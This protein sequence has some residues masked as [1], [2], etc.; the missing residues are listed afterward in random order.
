M[1]NTPT[2]QATSW[3]YRLLDLL[4]R[5]KEMVEQLELLAKSQ[6]DLIQKGHTD[7]LLELLGRR[8]TIID[9]FTAS[10]SQLGEFTK[11]LDENMDS[12]STEDRNRIKSL[13]NEIGERLSQVMKRDEQ[14]QSNL[15]RNRDQVKQELTS[16][17]TARQARSAYVPQQRKVTRFADQHG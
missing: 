4:Y 14:D 10:Q 7:R 1:S 3:S 6:A 15:R 5:Q 17:D 12:A 2:N 9:Q 8:Q 13:I 16:L 11:G